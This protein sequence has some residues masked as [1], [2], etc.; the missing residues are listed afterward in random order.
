M[1]NTS[2]SGLVSGLDTSTIITQ[3][4]QI[5]SQPQ[6]LLKNKV[7]AEQSAV[8]S[9]QTVNAR[10]VALGTAADRLLKADTWKAA[11]VTS[12][13]SVVQASAL[14]TAITGQVA[15]DVTGTA[16]A[17]SRRSDEVSGTTAVVAAATGLD[18]TTASG[19]T[20][21]D[22]SDT[23]LAGVVSAINAKSGLGITAQAVQTATGIYRLQLTATKTG[24][25]NEFAVA[26][27]TV[28]D[29]VATQAA[30]ATVTVGTGPGK[31]TVS[32]SSN[33]F[34]DVLPGVTFTVAGQVSGVTLTTAR[35]SGSIAD[36]VQSM[37]DSANS[38]LTEIRNQ[39]TSTPGT[40]GAAG[41]SSPLTGDSVARALQNKLVGAVSNGLSGGGSLAAYGIQISRDGQLTFDR[42]K[43]LA[44][45]AADPSGV[46]TGVQAFSTTVKGVVTYATDTTVGVLTQAVNG[47]NDTIKDLNTQVAA[48]DTRLAKRQESLQRTYTALEVTLG[49]LKD[50][51]SWLTGQIANLP[52]SSA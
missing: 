11:S 12:S 8:T 17:H 6:T 15:L 30:N 43:F 29:A 19:T 25:A 31:Y 3:L 33:T 5:E 51:A 46:Q 7:T 38:T 39:S 47:R 50:Q 28:A 40:A 26:G 35:N 37:V 44:S 49:K 48:W 23:S 41:S 16:A 22:T 20:H 10:F 4:M 32:S 34:T 13:S 9:L 18:F 27:L 21:V 1:P 42:T 52:T 14:P 2:I 36:A 24:T 45:Y